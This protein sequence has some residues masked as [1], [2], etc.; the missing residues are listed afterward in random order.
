MLVFLMFG[1]WVVTV[2]G[3]VLASPTGVQAGTHKSSRGPILNIEVE[4][5]CG[6]GD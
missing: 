4:G 5:D 1:L 2:R 3:V 6:G